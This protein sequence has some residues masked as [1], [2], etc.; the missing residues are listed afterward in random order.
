MQQVVCFLDLVQPMLCALQF[1]N[2]LS[3]ITNLRRQKVLLWGKGWHTDCGPHPLVLNTLQKPM[4]LLHLQRR[5]Q[6]QQQPFVILEWEGHWKNLQRWIKLQDQ[7]TIFLQE[8]QFHCAAAEFMSGRRRRRRKS[9]CLRRRRRRK[10]LVIKS[11]N[12]PEKVTTQ[13]CQLLKGWLCHS[14]QM[15]MMGREREFTTEWCISSR[16][17][18]LRMRNT[19]SP[20]LMGLSYKVKKM[21]FWQSTM[22]YFGG[23]LR[24]PSLQNFQAA[25]LSRSSLFFDINPRSAIVRRPHLLHHFQM[26]IRKALAKTGYKIA[27]CTGFRKMEK[28]VHLIVVDRADKQQLQKQKLAQFVQGGFCFSLMYWFHFCNEVALECKFLLSPSRKKAFCNNNNYQESP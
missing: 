15:M 1:R 12:N 26:I 18:S 17:I 19:T 6:Q 10:R 20:S 3:G 16:S 21:G 27:L 22:A 14:L 23:F 25:I 13:T 28:N 4:M 24:E 2:A 8:L 7:A 5:W 11:P 9:S